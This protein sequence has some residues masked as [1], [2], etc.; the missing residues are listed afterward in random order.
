MEMDRRVLLAGV[1]GLAA[2]PG[3]TAPQAAAAASGASSG[4]P[5]ALRL[6][7]YAD[8]FLMADLDTAT[9][10]RAKVHLL[11]SLGCGIAAFNEKTVSAVRGLALA[12]GSSARSAKPASN[13]LPSPMA[14][15]FALTISTMFMS[16]ARPRIRATTSRPVL[17]R[18]KRVAQAARSFFF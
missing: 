5:L 17:P 1:A 8:S 14:Q 15:A 16:A 9:I 13:G 11:D 3:L 18:R 4:P 7:G 2:A 12:S 10:E 6:A